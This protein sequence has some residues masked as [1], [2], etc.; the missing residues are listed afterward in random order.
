MMDGIIYKFEQPTL[1]C[2]SWFCI[3]V[4]GNSSSDDLRRVYRYK[5]TP[6]DEQNNVNPLSDKPPTRAVD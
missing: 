6:G 2:V 1:F 3:F 4:M 5:L